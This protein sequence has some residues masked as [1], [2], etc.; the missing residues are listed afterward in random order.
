MITLK[1]K[2][3]LVTGASSG[4]GRQIAITASELGAKLTIIGRNIEKLDET[5]ALLSGDGHKIQ[6]VDLSDSANFTALISESLPYDGVVFNAGVVEYLPVKFLNESK[7]NSVFATNF[8]SNVVLSQK[9]IKSKLLK[10]GGSLVF[11]SSISSKLGVP[12]TAMYTA[13]K[14]ALSAFSKVLASELASQGIRS[15]SV[16]PGIIKTAMT[17]K[18]SDVVSD[19]EL[20]KAESE[21]PLGYGEPSDVAGL[22]MYLLSDISKWMTGSDLIIDGGFTLK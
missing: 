13:S 5:L 6:V 12:G 18:A 17:D 19:E 22:I 4:I 14:A 7:I 8:D 2:N 3:I 20:K 16:S 10:K 1:D 9:L 21:Y 11:V 15:N